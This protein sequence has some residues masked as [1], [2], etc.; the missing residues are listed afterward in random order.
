MAVGFTRRWLIL[1][2]LL[3]FNVPVSSFSTRNF[4][5]TNLPIEDVLPN[6]ASSLSTKPNLLL[7][8][9]PGAG[10]TTFVPLNLLNQFKNVVVVEPRRVAARSA[11]T[12]MSKLLHEAVGDTV[13]Y[14]IRGESRIS[15]K[16]RI[17]VMTNGVL[18]QK[19]R[20]NPELD[21]V[22]V[23]VLDEFHERGVGSD[24]SLALCRE[25]QKLLRE[26]LKIVVMSATLLGSVDV[27]DSAA[28]RLLQALGGLDECDVVQSDGRQYQ[29]QVL[30]ANELNCWTGTNRLLPLSVL[31]KDRKSLVETMC[32]AI[33]QGAARAPSQGDVLAF[34]P[35][36]AEIRQ[37]I[38]MLKDRSNL[39][40]M[41]VVPLY[42]ALSRKGQDV[43]LFPASDSPRRVIVSSPIA[44]ASLTLERVTCVVDS[45]L[46]REP[47]CD[48]DTG[49]PRLVTCRC[50]K[51]SATQRA[52]RAGRV[53]EGLCIRIYTEAEFDSQ[54][55]EHAPPE[56]AS[57]D[58][59][60][61]L[62]LLADWGCASVDEILNEIPFVD[63]PERASLEKALQLLVDLQAIEHSKNGRLSI[64]SK[65]REIAKIPTHPRFATCIVQANENPVKLAGAVAVAFLMDDEVGIRSFNTPD[66]AF[67]C[68]QLYQES[69]T[70]T[71]ALSRYAAR[72]S[73]T[74]KDAVKSVLDG[75]IDI[76]DVTSALGQ[77]L[78]PGFIDLVAER[79]GDASYGGSMYMLSLG[80]SARLDDICNAPEYLVVVD[81]S[82]SDDG[83]ARIRAF[84]PV[85][86]ESLLDTA[87]E[88]DVVFTV[89]SRGHE[90]RAKR[91]LAVGE[92][93][94]SSTPLPAPSPEQIVQVLKETIDSLGGVHAAL[95]QSLPPDKRQA[96][97]ELC[98]RVRLGTSTSSSMDCRC[99]SALNAEA[100]GSASEQD[101]L[102]LDEL[103]EPWL[104]AAGS[105]KKL[106]LYEIL[107]SSLLPDEQ[108]QLDIDYPTRIEAPDKSSIP[109]SYT[110]E[111][112]TASAKL[113]QFFGTTESPTVGPHENRLPLSLSLLSPSGKI[114]AQTV[115]LPFFWKET[116]PSV[117][118]EMRGRYP[119]HPWPE[120]P[121]TAA[122]TRQTKKQ[123]ASSS[124]SSP[125]IASS[126]DGSRKKKRGKKR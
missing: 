33:E 40:G 68:R 57:T 31:S 46:R 29:I 85:D 76:P 94:L 35:G 14:I 11:A 8:A 21:D 64:T 34:L 71:N 28:T 58:L 96:L 84:A 55:L 19:L 119:K 15:R 2:T 79:K 100:N 78:L 87:V 25:S 97:D 38:A 10:K 63:P 49:M 22:D 74:A 80:R 16:T 88:R 41:E 90:V 24:V 121:M 122:A 98:S 77:A 3:F 126:Y 44:E 13:G 30:W 125:K 32:I 93:E 114:L 105:L 26:D 89:P 5:D 17:T 69:P 101:L 6:V 20:T 123:Q 124:S 91:I 23:V 82:T 92:L 106:N 95:V 59:S 115:D 7:E 72:I 53:Q 50:S 104:V 116:Y 4:A 54:F 111:I 56:I 47:R 108:R 45:G 27:E 110:N 75:I 36:A 120:D 103:L 1:A 66:L 18:L 48:V 86:K 112:P 65:G 9:P 61:T 70:A 51:A 102:L 67:R 73:S 12:R 99:F 117:R 39:K 109:V 43:A 62:L 37:T 81:T 42:G 83:K 60:D 107:W 113:Q 52:G 118:A